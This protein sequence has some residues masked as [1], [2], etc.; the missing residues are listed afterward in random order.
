MKKEH[1]ASDLCTSAK[2]RE[3]YRK[4]CTIVVTKKM[5]RRLHYIYKQNL[6]TNPKC[7]V[8]IGK[9]PSLVEPAA[10]TQD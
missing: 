5:A 1:W 2:G 10:V 8:K 3:K 4:I 7:C 9:K 6:N